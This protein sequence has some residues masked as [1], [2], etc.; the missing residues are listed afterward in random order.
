MLTTLRQGS[1]GTGSGW[2]NSNQS[3]PVLLWALTCRRKDAYSRFASK[4]GEGVRLGS[5]VVIQLRSSFPLII[6]GWKIPNTLPPCSQYSWGSATHQRWLELL[7]TS[8]ME[9]I[10][11]VLGN[12]TSPR[13]IVSLFPV[14]LFLWALVLLDQRTPSSS[15]NRSTSKYAKLDCLELSG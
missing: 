14:P 13:W 2:S 5:L 15:Q 7:P 1:L 3:D 9:M 4:A 11:F 12:T 6:F 10:I 8:E